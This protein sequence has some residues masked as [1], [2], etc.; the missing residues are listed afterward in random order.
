MTEEKQSTWVEQKIAQRRRIKEQVNQRIQ[1]NQT[2]NKPHK[3]VKQ[4]RRYQREAKQE[5]SS[6]KQ[7]LSL[8]H[9]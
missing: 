5:V 3:G 6:A 4:A 8:I 2:Q 7:E 1:E 9:I